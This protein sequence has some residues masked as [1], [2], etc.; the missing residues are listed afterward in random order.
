MWSDVYSSYMV[1]LWSDVYS[2]Y[3][4]LLWSDVYS[5]C[6][7]RLWSDVYSSYMV[8]LW[9]DVHSSYMARLWSDVY[10]SCMV[11]LLSDVYS[12]SNPECRWRV[13]CVVL[14]HV[15]YLHWNCDKYCRRS[16]KVVRYLFWFRHDTSSSPRAA[17]DTFS[18]YSSV[19]VTGCYL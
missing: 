14:R 6:M 11:S 16:L 17:Q 13:V 2:S 10:S 9:S 15:E 1:S 18:G 5:S 8:S 12:S 7:A 19:S 4:V 3:I